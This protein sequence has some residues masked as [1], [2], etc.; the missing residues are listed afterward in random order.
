MNV[1]RLLEFANNNEIRERLLGRK[2]TISYKDGSS[3]TGTITNFLQAAIYD[4]FN[5]SI[6]G[7]VLNENDEILITPA[8]ITNILI[9]S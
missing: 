2:I 4:D 8:I 6:I 5:R 3:K 9:N 7:L 1:V